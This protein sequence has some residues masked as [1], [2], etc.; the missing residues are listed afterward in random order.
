MDLTQLSLANRAIIENLAHEDSMTPE[1][2]L[3]S[4]GF[5][6]LDEDAIEY[7]Q[8][9]DRGRHIYQGH[10]LVDYGRRI[11]CP[12]PGCKDLLGPNLLPGG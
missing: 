12:R 8:T 4:R 3:T 2:W 10:N 7:F 6:V 9:E 5:T 1:Q 11:N